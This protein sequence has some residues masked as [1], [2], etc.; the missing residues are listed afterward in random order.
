MSEK[1]LNLEI[2]DPENYSSSE[3]L[4]HIYEA[5]RN[6]REMRTEAAARRRREPKRAVSYYRSG[7]ESYLM[8]LDTLMRKHDP[9]PELLFKRDF[10]TVTIQTPGQWKKRHGFWINKSIGQNNKNVKVSSLPEP[11]EVELN[12]L[13]SLIELPTPIKRTFEFQRHNELTGRSTV[14]VT[15]TAHI[16][17]E[18]LNRM[19]SAINEF[20]SELGLGL[21]VDE[22]DEWKI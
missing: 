14:T 9:G 5:R 10:G 13:S 7:V 8:E 19:V 20:V 11:K 22:E 1:P 12:G 6:L 16:P 15:A 17:W 18:T 4:K 3:R 21:D 2:D